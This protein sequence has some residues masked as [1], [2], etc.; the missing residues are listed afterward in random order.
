MGL[1][2]QLGQSELAEA[3]GVFQPLVPLFAGASDR[4]S[5]IDYKFSAN[6]LNDASRDAQGRARASV[7]QDH[8][9]D[10]VR[11]PDRQLRD[12]GH[13]RH[14]PRRAAQR[15]CDRSGKTEISDR[16]VPHRLQQR[17]PAPQPAV[18]DRP[19]RRSRPAPSAST[20][21]SS[22]S[23]VTEA[24]LTEQGQDP[25][26]QRRPTSS[27]SARSWRIRSSGRRTA[28]STAPGS[29]RLLRDNVA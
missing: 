25:R 28:S 8:R 2:S 13:R 14:F 6:G 26:P 21:G 11:Y 1:L 7:G 10:A 23:L 18:P 24:V 12:L 15:G 17:T 16:P 5:A 27:S 29:S 3:C 4:L 22:S 9:H 19:S 20:S